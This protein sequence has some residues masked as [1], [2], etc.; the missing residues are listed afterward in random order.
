M[1]REI[2][3]RGKTESGKWIFGSLLNPIYQSPQI[4]SFVTDDWLYVIPETV[5]QFT[6]LTDKNGTKI[7]EGD[8]IETKKGGLGVVKYLRGSFSL[9]YINCENHSFSY[10]GVVLSHLKHNLIGNIY[11]NPELI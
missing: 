2:L 4:Y 6:G 9:E 7:F 11:D 1:K 10:L 8:L 5:G 3:F